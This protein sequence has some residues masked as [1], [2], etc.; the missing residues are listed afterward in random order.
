[1]DLRQLRHFLAAAETGN[2]SKAAER[3]LVSQPALSASIAKLEA[4]L[5]TTLFLRSKRGVNL[6]S[7]GRRLA[8]TA[9]L[10]VHE[11]ARARSDLRHR[12]ALETVK[13]GVLDTL[14][15][16]LIMDLIDSLRLRHPEINVEITDG[17]LDH[18]E[19]LLA[20]RRVDI[21]LRARPTATLAVRPSQR[22]VVDLFEETLV[23]LV[24]PDHPLRSRKTV[25]IDDL[26][27]ERF[28]ARMHCENAAVLTR[29]AKRAGIRLRV[30]CRTF[31]DER[32]VALVERGYGV[33]IVPAHV[34]STRGVKISLSEPPL[35]RIVSL[36]TLK[37]PHKAAVDRFI[38][39]AKSA[40]W[41]SR[42]GDMSGKWLP[43]SQSER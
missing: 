17:S 4:S 28:I 23:L 16:S 32:A 22:D 29:S 19:H 41:P 8:E 12:K 31:Q 25:A 26:E 35:S 33:S 7:E 6:T 9:R 42:S 37:H 40:P 34:V 11:C 13:I 2:F 27:G 14:S 38:A 1:M 18:V 43:L 10:I 15:T 30:V 24:P 20:E 3:E 21:A 5:E 36:E 39:L